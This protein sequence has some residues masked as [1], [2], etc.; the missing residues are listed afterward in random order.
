MVNDY[1]NKTYTTDYST[2]VTAH[3]HLIC[4]KSALAGLAIAILTFA[5]VLALAIAFGGIGLDDGSSVKNASIFAGASIIVA[6]VLA[7]FLGSYYSVRVSKRRVD[8]IGVMQGLLVGA[9]FSIF[10]LWQ[11]MSAV[12]TMGKVAGAALGASATVAGAGAAAASQNPMVQD[13]IEDN[14]GDVKLKSEPEVV[15]RKVADRLIRGDQEGAKNYLA[16]QAGITPAEA[17]Q[18]IAAAKAKIDQAMLETR[19][20]AATTLKAVGWSL[21]VS[22]VLATIASVLGGL[23]AAMCNE[24][25]TLDAPNYRKKEIKA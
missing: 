7:N 10:V 23:A 9:L 19:K 16:Y 5:G 24:R 6:M 14:M 22:I 17:D 20:A 4:W 3:K 2:E 12:G 1:P 15:V 11:T 18:K 8:V 13:I 25:W 21:F